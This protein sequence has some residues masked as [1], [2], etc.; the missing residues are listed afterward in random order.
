MKKMKALI[1]GEGNGGVILP[2]SHYGRDSLVAAA[3]LLNRLS[4]SNTPMSEL[5]N[6]I[7][8]YDIIKDSIQTNKP[9]N[10]KFIDL[11]KEQLNPDEINQ[12][13]GVKLIWNDRWIHI[14]KSNTEPIVRFYSEAHDPEKALE[15]INKSKKLFKN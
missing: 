5:Y 3:L 13:D 7:P 4:M 10:S 1:G 15:L 8:H 11:I 6:N 2:E 14:R 12:I 9:I